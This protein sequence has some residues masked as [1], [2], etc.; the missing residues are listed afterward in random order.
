MGFEV[1]FELMEAVPGGDGGGGWR[2]GRWRP[3]AGMVGCELGHGDEEVPE[4]RGESTV[5]G[6]EDGQEVVLCGLHGT[7]SRE[8]TMLVGGGKG[9]GRVMGFEEGTEWLG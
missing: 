8:G 1:E 5:S 3:R 2:V 9:D 4:T 6:G 7:F